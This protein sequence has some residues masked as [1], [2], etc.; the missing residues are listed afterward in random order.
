MFKPLQTEQSHFMWFP[1]AYPIFPENLCVSPTLLI[2]ILACSIFSASSTWYVQATADRT[3]PLYVVPFSIPNLSRKLMC[4]S[5][6]SDTDPCMQ[7]TFC[8]FNLICSSHCRP[9]KSTLSVPLTNIN[10]KFTSWSSY[11]T[12]TMIFPATST[13][14]FSYVFRTIRAG[15]RGKWLRCFLYK[16]SGSSDTSAAVSSC[17]SNVVPPKHTGTLMPLLFNASTVC[18]LYAMKW[19]SCSSV[20]SSV[21]ERTLLT[22]SLEDGPT[23][24]PPGEWNC[25]ACTF[26]IVKFTAISTARWKVRFVILP[27]FSWTAAWCDLVP[28]Q[29]CHATNS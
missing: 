8:Q 2:Q 14:W 17:I 19:S 15:S 7:H 24:A 22:L 26:T 9:N 3:K 10:G 13:V 16:L 12:F 18:V 1:S 23:M 6:T 11:C 21:T 29:T 20:D 27:S 28:P 25:R 4:F 5:N